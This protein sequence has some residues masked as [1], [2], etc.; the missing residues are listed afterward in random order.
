MNLQYETVSEHLYS[1]AK[2]IPSYEE[3]TEQFGT[4]NL[5]LVCNNI[6]NGQEYYMVTGEP[7][8]Y[9]YSKFGNKWRK[10]TQIETIRYSSKF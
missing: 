8:F 2:T 10:T 4:L 1:K 3:F 6:D 5:K 7:E 9:V